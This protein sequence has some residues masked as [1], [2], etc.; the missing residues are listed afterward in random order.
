[1]LHIKQIEL[2]RIAKTHQHTIINLPERGITLV[3]GDNGVGKSS[4]IVEGPA[5]ALWGKTLRGT[6][7][8]QNEE[9]GFINIVTNNFS[10]TCKRKPNQSP[11]FSFSVGE[12]KSKNLTT[13]KAR[14]ALGDLI[15]DWDTWRR[16]AVF[17]SQDVAHFTLAT[18]GERKKLVESLLDLSCFDPAVRSCRDDLKKAK[19]DFDKVDRACDLLEENV[20]GLIRELEGH[21]KLEVNDNNNDREI[22]DVTALDIAS[23]KI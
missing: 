1:M 17:S 14:E 7:M 19:E 8:W 18:D 2:K 6:P 5:T 22:E 23:I 3:T 4:A 16:T 13:T 21:S 12:E 15:E 11:K 10:A 9:E 20:R